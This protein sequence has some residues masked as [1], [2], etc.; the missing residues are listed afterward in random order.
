MCQVI[1]NLNDKV[2][3]ELPKLP[4]NTNLYSLHIEKRILSDECKNNE[5]PHF[6]AV[7]EEFIEQLKNH[8]IFATHEYIDALSWDMYAIATPP[9]G[10]F[11][12]R[13]DFYIYALTK[14]SV[15]EIKDIIKT[16][17]PSFSI[18]KVREELCEKMYEYHKKNDIKFEHTEFFEVSL[19]VKRINECIKGMNDW[20]QNH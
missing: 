4:K 6:I 9:Q 2:I 16:H 20:N 7:E 17:F 15:D 13:V 18:I 8:E 10:N 12:V 14:K 19:Y 11:P 5:V 1:D 3:P